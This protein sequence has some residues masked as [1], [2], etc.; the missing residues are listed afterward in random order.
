MGKVEYDWQDRD[1]VLRWFGQKEGAAQK[2]YCNYV[3]KGIEQGR[4]PELVG[5]G[6][7][8]FA[9]TIHA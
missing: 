9:K 8:R 2:G 7:I 6:L 1:Y 3:E 4:R 5:G